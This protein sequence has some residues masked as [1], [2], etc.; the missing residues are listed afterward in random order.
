MQAPFLPLE[1]KDEFY[2]PIEAEAIEYLLAVRKEAEFIDS[3][4]L[5]P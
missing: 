1:F 4:L 5:I 3:N 2:D